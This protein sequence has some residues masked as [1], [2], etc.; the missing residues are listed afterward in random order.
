M[1]A[2][3]FG[4]ETWPIVVAVE[5]LDHK[6]NRHHRQPSEYHVSYRDVRGPEN[7]WFVAANVML[8]AIDPGSDKEAGQER[9]RQLL[10]KRGDTQPT[11][12]PSCGSVFRNPEGEFAARLIESSGLK[13]EC[14]GGAC[15]SEMHA[16]FI[17]NS[18][19]ATAGDIETLIHK[20]QLVVKQKYGIDLQPEVHII[21]EAN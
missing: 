4:G 10:N 19:D 18:G 20:V 7:E 1:N 16:N 11:S 2:G 13:G 14:I 9:I 17:I 8:Q 15:V 21:G 3:A 5:T 12:K 6:G